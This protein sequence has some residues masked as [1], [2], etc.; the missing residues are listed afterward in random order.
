M[1]FFCFDVAS[2]AAIVEVVDLCM[3]DDVYLYLSI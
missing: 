1:G 3:S 2:P